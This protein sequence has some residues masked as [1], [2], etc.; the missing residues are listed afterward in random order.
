MHSPSAGASTK[1]FAEFRG[2]YM[3]PQIAQLLYSEDILLPSLP[4]PR[5]K[6]KRQKGTHSMCTLLLRMCESPPLSLTH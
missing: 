3:H 5:L 2:L 4:R 1:C 6:C